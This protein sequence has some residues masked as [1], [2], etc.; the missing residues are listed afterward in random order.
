MDHTDLIQ[1]LAANVKTVRNLVSVASAEEIRFKPGPEKWSILEVINHLFDEE[2]DDFRTRLRLTLEDQG[3][4]WPPIDP[5]GW[6]VKR[7]YN[8][9]DFEESHSNFEKERAASLEWLTRLEDP[10]WEAFREH[11][12]AGKLTAGDL[13]SAWVAHDF[14]HIRQLV[15]IRLAYMEHRVKPYSIRYASP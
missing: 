5:D 15:N 3:E 14:L 13:L 9:R 6:A 1:Q 12:L 4:E 7:R 2:K 8:E 11:P 10:D